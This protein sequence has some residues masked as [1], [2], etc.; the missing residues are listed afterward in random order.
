M[1]GNGIEVGSLAFTTQKA[2][3]EYFRAILYR[4]GLGATIPEPDATELRWLLD[5]HPYAAQKIGCGVDRFTTQINDAAPGRTTGFLLIRT[6]GSS[7]DFS[8][9]TCIK[10]PSALID[11]KRAMRGEITADI[12][13]AKRDYF[14]KHANAA[15]EICCPLTGN[16]ITIDDADADHGIVR[17]LDTLIM[18]FLAARCIKPAAD[19]VDDHADNQ[20]G[21]RMR[22][23]AL[24]EAW[25]T[26]HHELAAIRVVA[27]A[28]NRAAAAKSKVRKADRQLRLTV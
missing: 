11:A 1:K 9:L 16:W 25:R 20:Y 18:A 12:L 13:A 24:A 6:D 26:Y 2:A 4:H 17:T 22:D 15:G 19:F 3:T 21:P 10:A 27:A 8:Y 28:A 5:R 23:R 14:A 7:T